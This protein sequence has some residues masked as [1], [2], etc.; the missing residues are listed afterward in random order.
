[1][2]TEKVKKEKGQ[3]A[4]SAMI[5]G[6]IP[7]SKLDEVR[8]ASKGAGSHVITQ[9]ANSHP[10][11]VVRADI[12]ESSPVVSVLMSNNSL[13]ENI[14]LFAE[15]LRKVGIFNVDLVAPSL[16][17]EM[18]GQLTALRDLSGQFETTDQSVASVIRFSEDVLHRT[19]MLFRHF[20][21]GDNESECGD[22]SDKCDRL[23]YAADRILVGRRLANVYDGMNASYTG[24]RSRLDDLMIAILGQPCETETACGACSDSESVSIHYMLDVTYRKVENLL[25][26]VQG[27]TYRINEI[28]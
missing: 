6:S 9:P 19:N 2:T 20:I 5:G 11:P 17:E 4:N 14:N 24:C 28:F 15:A 16:Y 21:E 27:A 8:R 12:R 7:K 3:K 18:E 10:A 22:D 26:A 13:I 25:S 1:M 23:E